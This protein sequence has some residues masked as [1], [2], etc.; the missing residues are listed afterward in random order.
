MFQSVRIEESARWE[1]DE[2]D[3]A[4]LCRHFPARR[5]LNYGRSIIPTCTWYDTLVEM[6]RVRRV[7]VVSRARDRRDH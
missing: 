5:L 2:L 7:I 4:S 3:V 1:R 6:T